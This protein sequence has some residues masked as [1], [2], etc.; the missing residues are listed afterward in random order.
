MFATRKSVL[1]PTALYIFLGAVYGEVDYMKKEVKEIVYIKKEDVFTNSK[2]ISEGAGITH[3]KLKETIKKHKDR[4]KHFGKMVARYQTTLSGQKEI[5]YDLNEP[6]AA[7]LMTLLKNTDT[8]LDFKEELVKQFYL[9]RDELNK[10][11]AIKPTYKIARRTLTDE[12]KALPDSPHKQFK[13]KQYT[14]LIYK[15]VLGKTS[16]Q[17]RKELGANK[18]DS[19]SDMLNSDELEKISEKENQV[20]TL[21]HYGLSYSQIKQMLNREKTLKATE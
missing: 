8:V 20:A 3:K 14:D 16:E 1:L 15:T 17:L 11:K 19:I 5:L 7:F 18:T 4:L 2:I 12:I 13:Y 10:R 6:Q 21:V 9:M